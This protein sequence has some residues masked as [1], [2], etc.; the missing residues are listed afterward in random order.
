MSTEM[1]NVKV[2]AAYLNLKEKRLYALVR[3]GRIPGTRIT[4]KWTF[5]KQAIDAWM[6]SQAW[7]AVE[8]DRRAGPE[9]EGKQDVGGLILAGSDDLL[10]QALLRRARAEWPGLLVSFANLGSLGGL[11]ALREGT[12]HMAGCHLLDPETGTYNVPQVRRLLADLDP[13]IVTLAF[14]KQGFLLPADRPDWVR[15]FPDLTRKGLR[16]INRQKGSGTRLLLDH[17]LAEG[18]IAPSKIRGYASEVHTHLEVGM[19][20]LAGEADV[21][22]ATEAVARALGLAF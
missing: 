9:A 6:E 20:V 19:A 14:R 4:G 10:I 12:A 1:M 16:F 7:T 15:D 8:V 17:R 22:L 5:P 2:R 3:Q 21:G 11:R 18:R 13:V